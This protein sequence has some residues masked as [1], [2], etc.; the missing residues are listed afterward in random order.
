MKKQRDKFIGWVVIF[1]FALLMNGCHNNDKPDVSKSQLELH[2]MRF[3]Q[4][5]FSPFPKDSSLSGMLKRRYGS[6]YDIFIWQLTR[7]GNRDEAITESNLRKFAADTSMQSVFRSCSSRFSDF[8]SYDEKLTQAFKYYSYYFPGKLVPKLITTVSLFSYPVI[9]DS[10]HLGISLDMYLDPGCNFYETLEPPLPNYLRKRMR[11]EYLVSDAMKGWAQSDYAVDETQA[12]MLQAMI[13]QGR[14]WYF[15]QKL[16]PETADSLL[17]GY[18]AS[19]LDWCNQNESQIWSFFI[20][21]KLLYSKDPNIML[22]YIGEGPTTNG[23][24]KESPGNIGQFI[25]FQIVKS[26]MKENK[27]VS[28]QQL[29]EEKDFDKIFRDSKYKPRR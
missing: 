23:F 7:L 25:G 28:L 17:S 18:S 1:T 12:N 5:L 3:E 26:F 14:I 27:K 9:C 2:S 8:K 11:P 22:K 16:L 20:K 15:L 4:D 13:S 10:T 29:M 19:Q 6:F 24:P 21:Q